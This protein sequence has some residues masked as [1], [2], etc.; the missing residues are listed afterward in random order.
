MT[1]IMKVISRDMTIKAESEIMIAMAESCTY[2][3]EREK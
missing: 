2:F 3:K 1:D